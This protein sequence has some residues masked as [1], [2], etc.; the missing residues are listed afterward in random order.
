VIEIRTAR[1][2]DAQG[3]AE[4]ISLSNGETGD[5]VF[6]F[7]EHGR[8]VQ[9]LASFFQHPRNRFSY[10]YTSIAE[11]DGQ[12]AGAL[13]ALPGEQVAG[14]SVALGR[15]LVREYGLVTALRLAVTGW[16]AMAGKEAEAGELYVAN[17]A[18]APTH[19]GQG[20]GSALLAHAET[21]ARQQGYA[22][23]SLCVDFYN[24]GA[25]RLYARLGY[26]TVE[27]F[28]TPKLKA[29]FKT[30]GYERMVKKLA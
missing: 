18:T 5:V 22:H 23:C 15:L 27:R 19:Q 14:L 25:R 30:D 4:L 7:G 28:P 3:A 17:V 13:I 10:H 26:E 16:G 9:A 6:G 12:A 11:V 24:Q 1:P 29:R 20:I 2:E 21:L 8:H